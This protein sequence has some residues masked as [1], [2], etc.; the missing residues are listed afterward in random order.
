MGVTDPLAMGFDTWFGMYS[1]LEGHRQYPH[2]LWRDGNKIRIK[3]N[4]AGRKGAYAQKLFASEAIEYIARERT[5]PFFVMLNFS[6]PHAE[7]AAPEQFVAVAGC[8]FVSKTQR[9]AVSW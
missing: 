7:L 3:E 9:H 5:N 2:F 1:I 6:S 4:E 8:E